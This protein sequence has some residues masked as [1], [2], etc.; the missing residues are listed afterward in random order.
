VTDTVMTEDQFQIRSTSS[1]ADARTATLKQGDMFAIVDKHG[2]IRSGSAGEHGIFFGDTRILSRLVL[3]ID[4]VRPLLLSSTV[5]SDNVLLTVDLTNPLLER[6]DGAALSKGVLHIQRAVFLWQG[7]CYQRITLGNYGQTVH[8]FRLSLSFG[9]DFAD[10]FEVSGVR[11]ERRGSFEPPEVDADTVRLSYRG[12]DEITRTTRLRF[13]S[14]PD[15]LTAGQADF[16][17]TLAPHETRTVDLAIDAGRCDAA[18]IDGFEAALDAAER[19]ASL[20]SGTS[21]R[22]STSDRQVSEWIDRAQSDLRMLVTE[23]DL[24]AYPY[25]GVPWFSTVFGRDGIITALQTL[26]AEPRLAR[27]VLC[28]LA[29]HQAQAVAPEREAEPGKILHEVRRGEMANLG[30][31]PFGRYYG[32]VDATPLFVML[33]GAYYRRTADLELIASIW[34]NILAALDWMEHYG[35][36]DGDG[37]VEYAQH[38]TSGLINQGWKDSQDSIFHADGSEPVGP[39]ALCEVQGYAFAAYAAAAELA[40]ALGE[41]RC[42]TRMSE[43]AWQIRQRFEDVFWVEELGTYAL[44]LDGNKQPCGVRSSNAGH[45]LFTGIATAERARSVVNTLTAPDMFCGWGVRTIAV[46]EARYNPMSYHNGSVWPHDNALLAAGF[47][48]YGFKTQALWIMSGLFDASVYMDLSRLPELF[49]GFARRPRVGPTLYPVACAPQAWAAGSVLLLL[50][51][52]LGMEVTA[53]QPV[54]RFDRPVLPSDLQ[55]VV[56]RNLSV[57]GAELDLSLHQH[58]DGVGVRV[59][60]RSGTVDVVVV[61]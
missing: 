36:V 22:I 19:T 2:D 18:D 55:E 49:C 11:R 56:I 58:P 9:A 34:P 30:E 46:G 52:C 4:G 24:G 44:A 25:A 23:T 29:A 57:A 42:A 1:I 28:Y 41:E 5:G 20:A 47:A 3:E 21:V 27:G 59:L 50:Q 61:K 31:V 13:S 48:R 33:A 35:D 14:A 15:Q 12:L 43:R 32:T 38:N 45:C 8:A 6:G 17:C 40:A 16:T 10:L 26:W 60:R 37:F 53:E 39:I 51:A 54:V 7:A